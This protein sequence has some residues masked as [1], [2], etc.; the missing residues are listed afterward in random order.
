MPFQVRGATVS[1]DPQEE[2]LDADLQT[3]RAESTCS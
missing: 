1:P 3:I 2:E